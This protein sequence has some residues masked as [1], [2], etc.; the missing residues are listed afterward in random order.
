MEIISD[1]A[2]LTG[3]IKDAFDLHNK[4]TAF[5]VAISGIDASGKGY[6]ANLLQQDLES[7][8]FNV[9]NINID[10]WQNPISIRLQKENAAENVYENIFRW[11]DFFEQLIFPLQENKSIYLQTH[12]IRSDA[13]V[14]YPLIYDHKNI[15]ILMVE[16]ILLFKRKYLPCYDFRIWIDCTFKTGLE[17][18]IK[19]NV[20][21][22][23]KERLIYDYDTYY[24]AGQRLHFKKDHPQ[25]AANIIFHNDRSA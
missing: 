17:R 12:G 19:R 9:A 22:L 13:D 3:K 20:E 18:A 16:G 24:Y 11:N 8:G 5:T 6:T 21:N 7:K 10:P 15:D 25:Q 1:I 4:K 23:T 2:S 14:Y